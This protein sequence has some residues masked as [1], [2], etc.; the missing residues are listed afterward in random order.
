MS[1]YSSLSLES[2]LALSVKEACALSSLKRTKFYQLLKENK[3]P[4]RKCG[5][6]TIVLRSDLE[7][8]L[9]SLPVMGGAS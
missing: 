1:A 2:A 6:R 9:R 8:F 4:A 5:R 7:D 3:I